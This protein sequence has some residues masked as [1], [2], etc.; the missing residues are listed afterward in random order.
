ML[1]RAAAALPEPGTVPPSSKERHNA[2]GPESKEDVGS[3]D[4]CVDAGA[5]AA[6]GTIIAAG[7]RVLQ[8]AALVAEETSKA[9]EALAQGADC[10]LSIQ[11]NLFA[12]SIAAFG[13]LSLL[14][15]SR[16]PCFIH[17]CSPL[18]S[19]QP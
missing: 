2:V 9:G 13:T 7:L 5:D 15:R 3:A 10:V 17:A 12:I 19:W 8:S 16:H 6:T 11:T 1:Q 18:I 14:H 4:A